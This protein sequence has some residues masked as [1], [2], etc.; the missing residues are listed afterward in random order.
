[1]G[2]FFGDSDEFIPGRW[3]NET[4]EPGISTSNGTWVSGLFDSDG[5]ALSELYLETASEDQLM[6]YNAYFCTLEHGALNVTE[7]Q[8]LDGNGR[9]RLCLEGS[10]IGY[11]VSSIY[12]VDT[13]ME[14]TRNE[15]FPGDNSTGYGASAEAFVYA[16]IETFSNW[17]CVSTLCSV[18]FQS[19]PSFHWMASKTF[20]KSTGADDL[21]ITLTKQK[22]EEEELGNYTET[23]GGTGE[24]AT[25]TEEQR[26]FLHYKHLRGTNSGSPSP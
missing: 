22:T 26:R 23:D 3:V 25:L 2:I 14:E 7:F 9:L 13:T 20:D 6:I 18:Q 17:T 24:E 19:D 11:D 12:V 5:E 8:A 16:P 4:F 15:T 1:M 21:I 10:Y